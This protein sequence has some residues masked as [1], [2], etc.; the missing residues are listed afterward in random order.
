MRTL[1]TQELEVV[2]GG[3][4]PAPDVEI[5]EDTEGGP[6]SEIEPD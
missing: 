3:D 2:S 5:V 4:E 6:D 1:E